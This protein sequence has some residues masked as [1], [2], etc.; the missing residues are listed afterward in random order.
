MLKMETISVKQTQK[1]ARIFAKELIN[2]K[3][4][5]SAFVVALRG[6]L[7]AGKTTFTQ[8]LLRG[9]GVKSKI[10]SPTFVLMKT[11]SL[12]PITHNKYKKAIHVDCYRIKAPKEILD[13]NW[14]EI[15][16]NPQNI[17]LIE[18]P[19]RIKKII[20]KNSIRVK[21]E[22]GKKENE[23]KISIN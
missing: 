8:G 2:T 22:Y 19:E 11:Y 23:R 5:R 15:I 9:L 21:F 6:N 16:S 7:G 14:K 3:H 13:L 17:V 12:Q 20:P 18:W 1:V 4:G 10:T